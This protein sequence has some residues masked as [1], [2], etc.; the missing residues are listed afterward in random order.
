VVL[1]TFFQHDET[2]C[3]W[4]L[5]AWGSQRQPLA[6]IIDKVVVGRVDMRTGVGP[7]EDVKDSPRTHR[8]CSPASRIFG[9]IKSSEETQRELRFVRRPF[10]GAGDIAVNKIVSFPLETF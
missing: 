10:V 8:R 6:I 1:S 2:D 9:K 5:G 7:L 4:H 3:S